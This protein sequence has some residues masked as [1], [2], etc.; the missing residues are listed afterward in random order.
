MSDTTYKDCV[1]GRMKL[2]KD[3]MVEVEKVIKKYNIE[4]EDHHVIRHTLR[5][6]SFYLENLW[7]NFFAKTVDEEF[8]KKVNKKGEE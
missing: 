8:E 7:L 4:P 1:K 6:R 5:T 2:V 3:V